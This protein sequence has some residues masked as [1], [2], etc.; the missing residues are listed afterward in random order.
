MAGLQMSAGPPAYALLK[1]WHAPRSHV[2]PSTLAFRVG[3]EDRRESNEMDDAPADL[4]SRA[5]HVVAIET[6]IL[7]KTDRLEACAAR[8]RSLVQENSHRL[9]PARCQ[10]TTL[11]GRTMASAARVFG[12]SWQTQPSTILSTTRN[13]TRL[14][15][16]AEIQHPAEHHPFLRPTPTAC[17]L[18]QDRRD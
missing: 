11:S 9:K 2:P 16:P 8:C 3:K 5:A 1:P 10:R 13:G 6:Q 14:R 18:R 15:L 12:N 7:T 17:N 4:Q